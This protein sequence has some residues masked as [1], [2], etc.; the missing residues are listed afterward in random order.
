MR[1]IAASMLLVDLFG[2][3]SEVAN[4]IF[5]EIDMKKGILFTYIISA[6]ST[7]SLYR[8][9]S[10]MG[11]FVALAC[12]CSPVLR[13]VLPLSEPMSGPKMCSAAMISSRVMGQFGSSLLSMILMKSLVLGRPIVFCILRAKTAR[14]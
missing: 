6:P 1:L 12:T 8:L 7:T 4:R 3:T 9:I 10:V 11:I 5:L 14:E 13:T 2:N